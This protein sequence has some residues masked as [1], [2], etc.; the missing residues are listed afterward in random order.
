MVTDDNGIW[1]GMNCR[2]VSATEIVV[3]NCY[4]KYEY[5]NEFYF[6]LD[7]INVDKRRINGQHPM[8][9]IE[10]VNFVSLSTYDN[11]S[12]SEAIKLR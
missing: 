10:N 12:T 7:Y 8:V 6:R 11:S 9:H 4:R 3:K 1:K 2:H 5:C